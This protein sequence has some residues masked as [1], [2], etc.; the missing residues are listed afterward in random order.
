MKQLSV[1]ITVEEV[2]AYNRTSY[3]IKVPDE[4][5]YWEMRL[6]ANKKE[7]LYDKIREKIETRLD[8]EDQMY[9]LIYTKHK[10]VK[11]LDLPYHPRMEDNKPQV[12]KTFLKTI[13]KDLELD[14]IKPNQKTIVE[15]L[16]EEKKKNTK[17]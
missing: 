15:S 6:T 11:P 16:E 13:K 17:K 12:M 4:G 2:E 3:V 10:L 8:Y 5:Y 1:D 7:E 9:E 14:K